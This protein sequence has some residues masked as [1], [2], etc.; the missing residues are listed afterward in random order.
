M[1]DFR[2]AVPRCA[3][4]VRNALALR[5]R[6]A[7]I[8]AVVCTRDGYDRLPSTVAALLRQTLPR[9]AY[10]VIIVDNSGDPG[11]A[12]EFA[13]E[14]RG[15][16]GLRVLREPVAGLAR[17]RN[18]GLAAV[19]TPLIAFTDDDA[20]PAADWL[21]RLVD[22]FDRFGPSVAVV[23]G[24]VLPRWE[25]PRPA[26]LT[27]AL[28]G[29]YAIVDWGGE[30]RAAAPEE[31]LAGV[32]I[33][34]RTARL[35]NV[36]GFDTRL[37]RIGDVLLGNEEI[38]VTNRFRARGLGVV[39]EPLAVVEHRIPA[40]R[41]EVEWLRKRVAWQAVSEHIMS[42]QW[43]A[44]EA[45]RLEGLSGPGNGASIEAELRTVYQRTLRYLA[46]RP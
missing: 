5:D 18:R 13:R 27:D 14:Y 23:G 25:A 24:R 30:A 45:A 21:G 9:D 4:R 35:R 6:R 8:T 28:L 17:A 15:T 19:R 36:G 20:V 40:H 22:A 41:L 34:F 1:R 26:W 29:Y 31:W 39:Y 37:G 16:P 3:R 10:R 7:R 44:M 32:N 42:P 12:R 2:A 33:A 46:G 11:P 43:A 38:A